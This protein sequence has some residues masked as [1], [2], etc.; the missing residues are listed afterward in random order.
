MI[1]ICAEVYNWQLRMDIVNTSFIFIGINTAYVISKYHW[2]H[3]QCGREIGTHLRYLK[4]SLIWFFYLYPDLLLNI[5][6]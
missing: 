1:F 5:T 4:I 3:L 6:L 2:A